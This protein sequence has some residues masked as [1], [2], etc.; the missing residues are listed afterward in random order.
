MHLLFF[1]G[2]LMCSIVH[3]HRNN[4]MQRFLCVVTHRK[5]TAAFLLED[6][7]CLFLHFR[8]FASV[9]RRCKC[10]IR[11][12]HQHRHR[13]R[14]LADDTFASTFAVRR[15]LLL[16]LLKRCKCEKAVHTSVEEKLERVIRKWECRKVASPRTEITR[17]YQRRK[18]NHFTGYT[19]LLTR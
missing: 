13:H 14:A 12:R 11:L 4:S 15:L 2:F 1:F 17:D 3:V 16:L 7:K 10:F 18:K 5:M 9:L 8:R 19:R 6:G